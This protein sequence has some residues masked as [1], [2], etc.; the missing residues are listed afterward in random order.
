MLINQRD[1]TAVNEGEA[2]SEG[3]S[4]LVPSS[5]NE[6]NNCPSSCYVL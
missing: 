5:K 1:L 3:I 6:P 4:N 2:V